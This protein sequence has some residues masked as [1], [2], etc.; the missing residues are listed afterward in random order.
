MVVFA[1][2]EIY[3]YRRKMRFS[4]L[5][6]IL[7]VTFVN[8]GVYA[9]AESSSQDIELQA[10]VEWMH[11]NGMTKYNNPDEFRSDDVLTRQEAAKFFSEFAINILYKDIDQNKFCGFDDLEE[12]DPSLK[13]HIISSCLLWIFQWTAGY[14]K[15]NDSFTKAQALAVLVRSL[16]GLSNEDALPWRINYFWK[17]QELGL[18]NETDPYVLDR[19]LLRY[20]M[21][22]LL[23]RAWTDNEVDD[24]VIVAEEPIEE[25]GIVKVDELIKTWGE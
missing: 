7:T 25:P 23:Y 8:I 5:V 1:T 11:T 4:V 12:A 13:N 14:F 21:A 16:E 3:F 6:T 22:L 18:T 9:L 19:P 17:A 2:S 10:A 24:A 15:P 20:E